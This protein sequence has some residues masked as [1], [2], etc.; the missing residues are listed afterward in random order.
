MIELPGGEGIVRRDDDEIVLTHDV[1][2][3]WGQPLQPHDRYQPIRI[4]LSDERM[5]FGG[6]LPPGAVSVEAVE[7]TGV[8]KAAAVG[9][10]TYAVIFEDGEHGEPALG[11]RDA[12]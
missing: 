5:L 7:A 11:Y 4:G 2:M 6:L 1:T 8:R 3:E 10:G 9:G 12:A